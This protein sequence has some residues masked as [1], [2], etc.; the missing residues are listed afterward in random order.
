MRFHDIS[1]PKFIEVFA[2]G[3]PEFSNS[4]LSTLSG[5]ELIFLDRE[6]ARQKYLIKNC[7]LSQA[8][9][10]EFNN[11]FRARRGKQFAFRF[12]DYSDYQVNKQFIAEGNSI[13]SEFQLFKLYAD[14]ISPY[15]RKITRLVKNNIILYID[16]DTIDDLTIETINYDTGIVTLKQPLPQK[17]T[18]IA[19]F[20]FDI[21]VRFNNDSFEYFYCEDGSIELSIIELVEVIE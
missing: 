13:L 4:S 6:N 16:N 5:R 17:K 7:R 9:F 3:V 11:F 12:R 15:V 21:P 18:L 2:I 8:Q 19:D 1:L 20:I 10:E 14:L